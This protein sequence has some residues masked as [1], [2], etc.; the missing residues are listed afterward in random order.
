[1]IVDG[2]SG[3]QVNYDETEDVW[4]DSFDKP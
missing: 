2:T 3:K 4:I 1:V